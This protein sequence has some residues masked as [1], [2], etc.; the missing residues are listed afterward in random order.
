[1]STRRKRNFKSQSPLPDRWIECPR[2]SVGIIS[3]LFLA[4]KTFLDDKFDKFIPR[5]SLF[6][7]RMITDIG[8][9]LEVQIGMVIDLTNSTRYYNPDEFF[10]MNISHAKIR[11]VG[12]GPPDREQV[13]QF[14]ELVRHFASNHPG[15]KILTHCTH[16]F[17]RTGYMIISYLVEEQGYDVIHALSYFA[18]LRPVGIYKPDYIE[19]LLTT[20]GKNSD[21]FKCPQLP[22]WCNVDDNTDASPK[23]AMLP[24]IQFVI[25]DPLVEIA[26]PEVTR[27]I[28]FEISQLLKSKQNV[29]PGCQPVSLSM[30]NISFIEQYPYLVSWK[31]DG[32]RDKSQTYMIDRTF[33]IFH[34][35]HLSFPSKSDPNTHL[36]QTILDGEFVFDRA[37]DSTI[38]RFLVFDILLF[39]GSIPKLGFSER[40]HIIKK[41]IIAPRDMGFANHS[42]DR[43]KE[44]FSV[45]LKP[46]FDKSAIRRL[47]EEFIKTLTHESDGLLFQ[48]QKMPYQGG[49]S[50]Y[51]LKWKPESLNSVDFY[52][53]VNSLTRPGCL[54]EYDGNLHV[55][56]YDGV[57]A[58][59][60]VDNE[61]KKY[62]RKIIECRFDRSINRWVF[63]RVR[64][65]KILPNAYST[66][67]SVCETIVNPVTVED[68]YKVVETPKPS[69]KS[70]DQVS[71]YNTETKQ[72]SQD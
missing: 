39:E 72:I 70:S 55:V 57:F 36:K 18:S 25:K 51:V 40:L 68:L 15:K 62:N 43:S 12:Q 7:P 3:D 9:S 11:C 2:R 59:I 34:I 4:T 53:V 45:R 24:D 20:N 48:P 21:E 42:I 56:G 44:A 29:F 65:D 31:A 58:K 54:P 5:K 13:H 37:G 69:I 23:T 46:F 27:S 19:S 6:K 22:D 52:L 67:L 66:A 35:P 64:E 32:T 10:D 50:K 1:M 38:P 30:D 49:T 14:I 33:S 60:K 17:N 61:L 8:S 47:N 41:E 28:K 71:D 26:A 16:G 63:L